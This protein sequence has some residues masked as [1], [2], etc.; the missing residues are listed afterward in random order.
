MLGRGIRAALLLQREPDVDLIKAAYVLGFHDGS[1]LSR[2]LVRV[3]GERPSFLRWRLSWE[4][5]LDDWAR[6]TLD[7]GGLSRIRFSTPSEIVT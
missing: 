3:F 4:W 1:G 6:K 7:G 2:H 5:L